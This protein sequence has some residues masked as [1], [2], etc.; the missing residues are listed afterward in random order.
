MHTDEQNMEECF[1]MHWT[2]KYTHLKSSSILHATC[3]EKNLYLPEM[4]Y[5]FTSTQITTLLLE[6]F[7]ISRTIQKDL[8]TQQIFQEKSFRIWISKVEVVVKTARAGFN[9]I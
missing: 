9:K 4:A 8:F 3:Q 7:S 1:P 2:L 6:Q 5:L